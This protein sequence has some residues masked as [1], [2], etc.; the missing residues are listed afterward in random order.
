M[1]LPGTLGTCGGMKINTNG[2]VL[3]QQGNPMP[4]LFAAGNCTANQFGA[5]YVGGGSTI[6]PGSYWGWTGG[7]Y[8]AKLADY[9][10][11]T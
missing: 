2:Q 8:A 6:G 1:I 11:A 7:K 3:D 10:M 5:A 4:G 9:T